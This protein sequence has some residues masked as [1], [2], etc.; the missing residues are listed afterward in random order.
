MEKDNDVVTYDRTI[1]V[2]ETIKIKE[3]DI[4]DIVKIYEVN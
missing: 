3:I 2:T 1:K 4:V